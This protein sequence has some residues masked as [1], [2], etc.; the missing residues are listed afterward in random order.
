MVLKMR[1]VFYLAGGWSA[2]CIPEAGTDH[3][4]SHTVTPEFLLFAGLVV[5]DGESSLIQCLS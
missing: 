5:D 3:G 1:C 4:V 2:F